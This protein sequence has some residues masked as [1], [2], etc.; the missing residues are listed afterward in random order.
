[1]RWNFS[2]WH[3]MGFFSKLFLKYCEKSERLCWNPSENLVSHLELLFSSGH[4]YVILQVKIWCEFIF[5]SLLCKKAE[6]LRPTSCEML[7][8]DGAKFLCFLLFFVQL[9]PDCEAC[10]TEM[11]FLMCTFFLVKLKILDVTITIR[12]TYVWHTLQCKHSGEKLIPFRAFS[13]LYLFLILLDN[14]HLCIFN[15]LHHDESD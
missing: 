5:T 14:L 1:M 8:T 3:N 12:L 7:H 15:W 2:K 13:E 4:F 11:E 10:F 6:E 9:M